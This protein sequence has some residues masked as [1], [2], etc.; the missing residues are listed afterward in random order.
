MPSRT[1]VRS[2]ILMLPFVLAAAP[3]PGAELYK[4][5]DERGVT[6]YSNETPP[7]GRTAKKLEMGEERFSVYTPD[8]QLTQAVEAERQKRSR[9]APSASVTPPA[10]P[11]PQVPLQ[12]I[13]PEPRVLS[14]DP[15]L[16]PG[17]PDC[18]AYI[19]D[20]SPLFYGR[21]RPAPLVQPQL[22]P[23]AIAGNVNEMKGTTP[24]LSG[25][26]PPAATTA[27]PPSPS[28]GLKRKVP[29]DEPK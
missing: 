21:R 22:P 13:S 6:N 10:P 11:P 17:N 8:P 2:A 27:A 20:S 5:V 4:W 9:P 24:G 7:K 14:Y 28:Y 1:L 29:K 26:T 19:Y 3:A 23:G 18:S 15:C 12:Q 25:V 16:T